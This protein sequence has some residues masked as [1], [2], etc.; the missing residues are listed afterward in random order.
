MLINLFAKFIFIV[1]AWIIVAAMFCGC[2]LND[3]R[4]PIGKP[5]AEKPAP[6]A[7]EVI[8]NI[9]QADN[10]PAPNL[11]TALVKP[12]S[13]PEIFVGEPQNALAPELTNVNRYARALE[14]KLLQRYN[15]TPQHAGNVAKVQL[16]PVGEPKISLDGKK[17]RVEW[18]QIVFDLWGERIGDLEKE[19]YV[20]TF[21]DGKPLLQRT[22]P[23]I[24]VGMNNEGGYSEYSPLRGGIMST[25]NTAGNPAMFDRP[26]RERMT[27][28]DDHL[29]SKNSA[30]LELEQMDFPVIKPAG[31]NLQ[32]L[33]YAN[34]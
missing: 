7:P 16:L 11:P 23:T 32:A 21:G 34:Y 3:V 28:L 17:M 5:H 8:I 18:S 12:T 15:N 26:N 4:Y 24:T 1:A 9:N 20:V 31:E 10:N 13:E 29:N 27:L 30:P 6:T 33:E 25:Q 2:S 22:R 19:F 14:E